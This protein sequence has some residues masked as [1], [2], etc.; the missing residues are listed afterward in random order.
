M[1]GFAMAVEPDRGV[2]VAMAFENDDQARRNADSRSELAAGPAPGQGGDFGERFTLGSVT[3]DGSV[4]RMELEPVDGQPRAL[5]PVD[6][7][8][9]L[10][11]LLSAWATASRSRCHH[12]D[13]TMPG[14]SHWPG[15]APS[16][17]Q[18]DFRGHLNDL[19]RRLLLTTNT[20]ER[21]IA[22]PASIGLSR[23]AAAS[24]SAATL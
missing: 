16:P 4:V 1:T 11:Y 22:A 9:A 6:R 17:D 3:A 12:R 21:A 8:R 7:T 15:P 18:V 14:S 2:R 10:C 20:D 23:P 5:R 19:S 24:G 13:L